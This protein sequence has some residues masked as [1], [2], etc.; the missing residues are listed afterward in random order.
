[1]GHGLKDVRE[2]SNQV[3]RL[4]GE[5]ITAEDYRR[6]MFLNLGICILGYFL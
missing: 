4:E 6:S 3:G 5:D 1:M 2:E